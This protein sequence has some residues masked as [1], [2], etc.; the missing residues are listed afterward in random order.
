MWLMAQADSV[1]SAALAAQDLAQRLMASGHERPEGEK[2]PICFDLIEFPLSE[3]GSMNVCCM[4]TVCKGCEFAAAL[5]GMGDTCPFCRTPFTKADESRLAMI[6][7]RVDKG[8]AI[9]IYVLGHMYNRGE[10]G[11]TKDVPRAIE[12]WTEAAELGSIDAHFYLGRVYYTGD[13]VEEDKPRGIRHWQQ[14]AMKGHAGSRHNLGDVECENGNYKVAVQHWMISVK[15][16]IEMSLNDIK[17]IFK[18]GHATKAQYA[19]ALMGYRDAV[20][21]T[22][23]PQREE[24]KRLILAWLKKHGPVGTLQV[25]PRYQAGASANK[26]ENEE[27]LV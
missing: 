26:N 6:Q 10:L 4:K 1:E 19:E 20:D 5:R 14:A 7:K 3:N 12:L 21:E 27:Q 13:G 11:L 8:D 18:K 9:A 16:G 17:D 23:S 22:K 25:H 2:C 24:A 15:M